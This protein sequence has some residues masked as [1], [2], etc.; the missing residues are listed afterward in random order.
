MEMTARARSQNFVT[1]GHLIPL[2]LSL[3]CKI[4]FVINV[5]HGTVK[6]T[7]ENVR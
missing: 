4:A 2:S 5:L 7:G 6:I 1:L 3:L